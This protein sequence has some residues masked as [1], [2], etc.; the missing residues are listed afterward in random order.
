[1]YLPDPDHLEASTLYSRSLSVFRFLTNKDT[2]AGDWSSFIG[3]GTAICGNIL[4]SFA[5]NT[6]RYAHIRLEREKDDTER[7][8]LKRRNGGEPDYGTQQ[9]GVA[10]ERE[11]LNNEAR[12][13]RRISNELQ[14]GYGRDVETDQL[15]PGSKNRDGSVSSDSTVRRNEKQDNAQGKSYLKS[16]YWWAGLV[17]ITIGEAGNF[18]AYGFA[19]ASIVSPLGVVALISNC[20]IAPFMLKER[21]RTRDGLGVL[22]AIA[23][24]VTVVLS[25]NSN[26]PKL[27]PDQ[28]W[29]FIKRW[30]FETYLGITLFLI[31]ALAFLSNKYGQKTILIDLGLVGLFGKM[32]SI[33]LLKCF[34]NVNNRRIYSAIH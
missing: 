13:G 4:I 19:P 2:N 26:D 29:D 7:K 3:I 24:A 20:I 5:L 16:P 15:L 14:N 8:R 30:E 31:I 12:V 28:I 10:E 11:R 25:A 21:F 18:L 1:M 27:G 17:M 32:T 22:V 34:A 6:Q 33:P 9:D 23:G